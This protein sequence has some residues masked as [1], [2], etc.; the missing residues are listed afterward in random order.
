MDKKKYFNTISQ[1]HLEGCLDLPVEELESFDNSVN[2][3]HLKFQYFQAKKSMFKEYN[4]II[5]EEGIQKVKD[6]V[7]QLLELPIETLQKMLLQRSPNM[8]FRNFDK[9]DKNELIKIL[10]DYMLLDDLENENE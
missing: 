1:I 8:Q 2:L 6:K 9:L 4:S 10:E 7:N 3:K 5:L